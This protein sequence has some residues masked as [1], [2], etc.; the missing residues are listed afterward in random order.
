MPENLG[1]IQQNIDP[2]RDGA[3]KV[4]PQIHRAGLSF[5]MESF[6]VT[7]NQASQVDGTDYTALK[8]IASLMAS[9][10]VGD[11]II[12]VSD[13]WGFAKARNVVISEGA[14]SETKVIQSINIA[15]KQLTLKTALTNSYTTAAKATMD[16]VLVSYSDVTKITTISYV[17]GGQ[18]TNSLLSGM[19][20]QYA[21]AHTE[22]GSTFANFDSF[23]A[24]IVVPYWTGASWIEISGPYMARSLYFLNGVNDFTVNA[25]ESASFIDPNYMIRMWFT[26]GEAT[27]TQKKI[28]LS[29]GTWR[30]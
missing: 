22:T 19:D 4:K 24:R 7:V 6:I 8:H 17:V 21:L 25:N 16:R 20:I 2:D 23:Q 13:V 14:T 11:T 28:A 27:P 5:Q 29:F 9:G 18:N 1:L 15:T 10:S 12:T 3:T 26:S 30:I